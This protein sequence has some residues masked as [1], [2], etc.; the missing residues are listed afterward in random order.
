MGWY[1]KCQQML[2]KSVRWL[3]TIGSWPRSKRLTMANVPRPFSA[4]AP[5]AKLMKTQR[6]L[7]PPLTFANIFGVGQFLP[8]PAGF[9]E[10][11]QSVFCR[12]NT[13]SIGK[14]SDRLTPNPRTHCT[15]DSGHE[16]CVQRRFGGMSPKVTHSMHTAC[17]ETSRFTPR[18]GHRV[19]YENADRKR[20]ARTVGGSGTY[21]HPREGCKSAAPACCECAGAAAGARA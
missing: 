14:Q 4:R 17:R 12:E 20:R 19:R 2:G 15:R 3:C 5:R 21:P 18:Y 1:T 8:R 6:K 13:P 7:C 16:R 10:L 11:R 9:S